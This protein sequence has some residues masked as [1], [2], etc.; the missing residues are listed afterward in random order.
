LHKSHRTRAT[1]APNDPARAYT[2]P[3]FEKP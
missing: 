2:N 3:R 1:L